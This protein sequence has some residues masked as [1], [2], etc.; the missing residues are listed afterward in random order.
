[1]ETPDDHFR[2]ILQY[3]I[4]SK[5]VKTQRQL[6][7]SCMMLMVKIIIRTTVTEMDFSF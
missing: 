1:M 4:T 3:F 6:R 2:H 7:K 5:K